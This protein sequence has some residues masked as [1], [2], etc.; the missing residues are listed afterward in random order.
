MPP[1]RVNCPCRARGERRGGS[2]LQPTCGSGGANPIGEALAR[3]WTRRAAWD[4]HCVGCEGRRSEHSTRWCS[5]VLNEAWLP[6]RSL[7]E[8]EG[9]TDVSHFPRI[10]AICCWTPWQRSKRRMMMKQDRL[11]WTV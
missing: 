10:M 4:A 11:V 9:Q 8:N 5:V 1:C 6:A 2:V 7:A 3:C